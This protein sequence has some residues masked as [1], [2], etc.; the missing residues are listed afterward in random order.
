MLSTELAT[1][2]NNTVLSAFIV[3]DIGILYPLYVACPCAPG[4]SRSW[5]ATLSV[6]DVMNE[7]GSITLFGWIVRASESPIDGTSAA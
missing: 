6:T 2:R 3:D 4:D 5:P 7:T 1:H